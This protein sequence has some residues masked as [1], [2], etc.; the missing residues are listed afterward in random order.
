MSQVVA[1]TCCPRCGGRLA[2]SHPACPHCRLGFDPASVA[3]FYYQQA[4]TRPG[5]VI[6]QPEDLKGG[7]AA[8]LRTR[9]RRLLAVRTPAG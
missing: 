3:A 5:L 8:N 9:L 2:T 6:M 7:A 1:Y 4:P